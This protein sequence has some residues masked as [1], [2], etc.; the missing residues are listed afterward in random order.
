MRLVRAMLLISAVSLAISAWSQTG[1]STIRGVV[2]DQSERV[3]PGATVLLTNTANNAVR[4]ATTTENGAFVFD[5]I[6]PS[7][8]RIEVEAKGFKKKVIGS[9]KALIG[10]QTESN[11]ELE[12]GASTEVVEVQASAQDAVINTQDA[13]LGNNFESLQITQLPLEARNITDL[14]TLQPGATREGYVTGARADQ[15]NI[16]SASAV[17]PTRNSSPARLFRAIG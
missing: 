14:L 11:I 8:Y 2:T 7:D 16:A 3:V 4:T 5:L 17:L 6:T 9:V 1:T 12:V 10:K 15:S 13:T